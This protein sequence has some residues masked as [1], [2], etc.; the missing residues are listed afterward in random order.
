MDAP[1]GLLSIVK[2]GQLH[3]DLWTS[4]TAAVAGALRL[5]SRHVYNLFAIAL[6]PYGT[7]D[8]NRWMLGWGIGG[9]IPVAE[10]WAIDIDLMGWHVNTGEWTNDFNV[11]GQLRVAASYRFFPRLAIF[12]GV[13]LNAWLAQD[14]DASEWRLGS[15]HDE[16][17]EKRD[18]YFASWPGVFAGLRF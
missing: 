3:G 14:D 4:D 11:L 10:E 17:F 18:L 16:H 7:D 9:H 12:A 13:S 1:I 8:R 15:L 5:G 2:E 6:N